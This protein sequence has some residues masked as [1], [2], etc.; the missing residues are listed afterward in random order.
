MLSTITKYSRAF[1]VCFYWED[2][3]GVDT[4]EGLYH[5]EMKDNS[6]RKLIKVSSREE[7]E[8]ANVKNYI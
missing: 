3:N 6:N 7:A 1:E 2:P 4:L 5:W 8:S